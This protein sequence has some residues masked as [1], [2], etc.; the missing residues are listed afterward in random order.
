[1]LVLYDS[2]CPNCRKFANLINRLDWLHLI[3]FISL[4]EIEKFSST[5][6]GIE[7]GI[8]TKQM[9][10]YTNKWR[11]GFISIYNILI[12]IPLFWAFIP[13]LYFLKITNIGQCIYIQL[14]LK[15]KIIPIHCD[16]DTCTI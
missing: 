5:L 15:R 6:S 1:M 8:A 11:Y 7:I 14:S 3:N 13:L 12:R 9:A 10:S 2:W 4:R 16:S